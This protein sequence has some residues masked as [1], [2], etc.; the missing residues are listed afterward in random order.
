LADAVLVLGGF[1][2]KSTYFSV[3]GVCL[4]NISN[5][6]SVKLKWDEID[7]VPD[8]YLQRYKDFALE[9]GDLVIALTRPIIKSLGSV[10]IATVG[11]MDAPSLLNQRVARFVFSPNSRID[12]S[13]LLAFCRTQFFKNAVRRFCSESLQPNMSTKQLGS[14]LIAQPPL[15]L[16][17]RF[18][19]IVESA[20]QQKARQR[21]HLAE[22]DTLFAS[23][24]SRAFR[25]DL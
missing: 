5:V 2:F 22:L 16:Q 21:A 19:A 11:P 13:Y 4:V 12:K 24:Q 8:P 1:A 14:V 10:K 17:Q 7:R 23:L 25:G 6:H 9:P 3:Q 20:E 18:A 15:D